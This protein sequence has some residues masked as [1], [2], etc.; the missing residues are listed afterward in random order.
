MVSHAELL[1]AVGSLL[2]SDTD[3]ENCEV[4]NLDRHVLHDQ[5]SN[6][7]HHVGQDTSDGTGREWGVVRSHVLC[8]FGDADGVGHNRSCIK[9]AERLLDEAVGTLN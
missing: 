4:L 7:D 5:F 2:W 6:A 3:A 9:L 1:L 8:Q